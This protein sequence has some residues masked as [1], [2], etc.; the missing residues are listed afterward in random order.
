MKSP[1]N[2]YMN[3]GLPP[4]P[5]NNPGLASIKAALHPQKSNYF[6]YLHDSDGNIHYAKTFTEHKINIKKYLK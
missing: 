1:Y 5:I 2:T 6:Y 3:K 4:T